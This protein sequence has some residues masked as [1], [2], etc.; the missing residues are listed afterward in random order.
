VVVA[1]NFVVVP[2][3]GHVLDALRAVGSAIMASDV[4]RVLVRSGL[5]FFLRV[6]LWLFLF[7]RQVH[8]ALGVAFRAMR[9]ATVVLGVLS[10]PAHFDVMSVC[11]N[12][13]LLCIR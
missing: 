13:F 4:R 12:G 5:V 1:R 11:L 7:P 10:V 9:V 2:R 6:A 3:M 8:S